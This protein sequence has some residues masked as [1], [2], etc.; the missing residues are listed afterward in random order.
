MKVKLAAAAV[1]GAMVAILRADRDPLWPG[2][3]RGWGWW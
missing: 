3:N 1:I 2:K